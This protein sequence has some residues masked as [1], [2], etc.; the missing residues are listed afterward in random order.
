M[1]GREET[2]EPRQL[3]KKRKSL[4]A[5]SMLLIKA[6]ALLICGARKTEED[7]DISTRNTIGARIRTGRVLLSMLLDTP[8]ATDSSCSMADEGREPSLRIL[9][10]LQRMR[11]PHLQSRQSSAPSNFLKRY[12]LTKPMMF[13]RRRIRFACRNRSLMQRLE[14]DSTMSSCFETFYISGPK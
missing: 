6:N 3:K 8:S 2:G 1:A 7:E 12:L 9:N 11:F 13:N 4:D 10:A 14:P 5:S